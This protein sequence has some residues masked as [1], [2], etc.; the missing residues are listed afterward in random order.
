MVTPAKETELDVI[1]EILSNLGES[2]EDY[3]DPRKGITQLEA[4]SDKLEKMSKRQMSENKRLRAEIEQHKR[5]YQCF[6]QKPQFYTCPKCGSKTD[7]L[8][9]CMY[10][11]EEGGGD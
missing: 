11:D 4:I 2:I 7:D 6:P 9:C 1:E 10:D 8:A 3:T 5:D